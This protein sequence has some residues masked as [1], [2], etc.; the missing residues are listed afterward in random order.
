[1]NNYD[2]S[3]RDKINSLDAVSTGDDIRD[4]LL[5]IVAHYDKKLSDLRQAARM[6]NFNER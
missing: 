3:L 6:R 5:E 4:V 2:L 1:L